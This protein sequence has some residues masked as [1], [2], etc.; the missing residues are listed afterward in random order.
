MNLLNFEQDIENRQEQREGEHVEDGGK[1]IESERC[2][3]VFF[4]G[5]EVMP[6]RLEE[7]SH[8][9][10]KSAGISPQLSVSHLRMGLV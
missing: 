10:P 4:V 8:F 3:H 2:R 9:R 5:G 6:H 1:D 7:F